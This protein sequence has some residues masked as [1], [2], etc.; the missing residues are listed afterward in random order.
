M[1]ICI[2]GAGAGGRS[3]SGKIRELDKEAQIDIFSKQSEIGYAPCELPFA[4]RGTFT[5]WD[6]IFYPGKFF[7]ENGIMVHLEAEVTDILRDEKRIIAGGKSYAYDKI[8]LSLG[9]RPTIP[10]ISGVNGK[11]EFAMSSD[12]SRW[13]DLDSVVSGC[14]SAAVI[15]SG[16]IGIE[17]T[18]ALKERGYR[19]VYLLEIMDHILPSAVDQDMGEKIEKVM[20][21]SGVDLILRA[22]IKSVVTESGKKRLILEDRELEVDL[23]I[24]ATGAEPRIDPAEKAGIRIGETGAIAVNQY[25]QTSDPDIYAVGDCMENW[26][27]VTGA[28]TRRLMVTTASITGKIAAM[29]LVKGKVVPYRGTT[30]TFIMDVSGH[31]VGAVGFTEEKAKKMGFDVISVAHKALKTRPAYGGKPV[32]CKIIA[33]RRTQ[34]LLGGQIVSQHEIGGMINELAV[35]FAEGVPLPDILRIDT[36][37]SPLIGPDPVRGAMALLLTKL[38]KA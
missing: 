6:G 7:E 31:E 36:P 15:G 25:L 33:D 22:R 12:I 38:D 16:A 14:S 24:F 2:I 10:N 19:Q 37:Y 3:A 5:D 9:A 23:L 35:V 8:I 13:K 11:N 17:T 28:K 18:Q 1:K 27:I 30:M 32:Y 21:D 4:M 34:T 29:N 20:V 26:D